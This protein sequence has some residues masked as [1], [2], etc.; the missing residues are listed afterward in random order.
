MFTTEVKL[1]LNFIEQH[2]CDVTY[3]INNME[4]RFVQGALRSS[5]TGQLLV[6]TWC[7]S[8]ARRGVG[9]PCRGGAHKI[10][11]LCSFAELSPPAAADGNPGPLPPH[12]TI[13]SDLRPRATPLQVSQGVRLQVRL[14]VYFRALLVL[15]GP[16]HEMYLAFDDMYG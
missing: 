7:T 1:R 12:G 6:I 9:S 13:Q 16:S 8:D 3:C 10:Y 2:A 4:N 15:K 14:L 5:H 11:F